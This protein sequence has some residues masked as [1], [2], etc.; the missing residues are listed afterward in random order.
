MGL[1]KAVIFSTFA[2]YFSEALVVRP[3]LLYSRLIIQSIAAFTLTPKY[4]K[5]HFTL[6]YVLFCQ[7]KFKICFFPYTESSAITSI[8]G[9]NN[10]F[11]EGHTI[12]DIYKPEASKYSKTWN[13]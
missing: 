8:L 10:I 4:V 3:T 2:R 11:G 1:S 13:I 7:V 9:V 6:N 12:G 5:G